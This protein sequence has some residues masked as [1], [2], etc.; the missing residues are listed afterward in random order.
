MEKKIQLVVEVEVRKT[1]TLSDQ[2]FPKILSEEVNK[3]PTKIG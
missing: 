2:N 3:K 1:R